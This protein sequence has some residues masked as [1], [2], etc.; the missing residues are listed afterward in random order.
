[1]IEDDVGIR[2]ALEELY[3]GEGYTV[4]VA[5]NGRVGLSMLEKI[6]PQLVL[7]DLMMPVLDGRGFLTAVQE[8]KDSVLAKTPVV[9]FTAAGDRDTA[10]FNVREILT[11]PIDVEKLLTLAQ[12][13]CG[14]A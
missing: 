6:R 10:G 1:M 2:S 4:A 9:L 13:Y 3:S 7:L 5:E 14:N 8:S 12:R 11:K